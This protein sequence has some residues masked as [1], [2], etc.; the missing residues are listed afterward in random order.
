MGPLN[1]DREKARAP[2][3][4]GERGRK[5]QALSKIR[6]RWRAGGGR[7]RVTFLKALA[8]SA[9][10]RATGRQTEKTGPLGG[11]GRRSV[12]LGVCVSVSAP[13][14][15]CV[16]VCVCLA[17]VQGDFPQSTCLTSPLKGCAEEL[18][19][20]ARL[21]ESESLS[22]CSARRRGSPTLPGQRR[23]PRPGRGLCSGQRSRQRAAE[24]GRP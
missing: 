4:P 13:A 9:A 6:A 22:G 12:G 3:P 15:V 18:A 21:R 11:G 10:H 24:R 23:G 19:S 7:A 14:P 2:D 1:K 16:R 20:G 17:P 8:L 5:D